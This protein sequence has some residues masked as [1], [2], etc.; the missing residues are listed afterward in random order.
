[1]YINEINYKDYFMNSK[2]KFDCIVI[3]SGI[4]GLLV[5]SI[6][7]SKGTKVLLLEKNSYPGGAY[8][9]LKI[10]D[11]EMDLAV[12]YMLGFEKEGWLSN[13]FDEISLKNKVNFAKI[14]V[15]DRYIFPDFE[16]DLTS[17]LQILKQKLFLEFPNETTSISEFFLI[18]KKLYDAMSK[19]QSSGK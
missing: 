11:Y 3:G 14:E 12:S 16:F 2:L 4:G 15:P 19:Y 9:K 6:L 17:D 7:T 5:S 18:V 8:S 1:M 13:L 10:K